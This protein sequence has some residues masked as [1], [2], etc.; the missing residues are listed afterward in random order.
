MDAQKARKLFEELVASERELFE[1]LHKDIGLFW[2]T[3]SQQLIKQIN[4]HGEKLSKD[5]DLKIPQPLIPQ[6]EH[7][8]KPILNDLQKR[9]EDSTKHI[10]SKL[11]ERELTEEQHRILQQAIKSNWPP[12]KI[13]EWLP[14]LK[15][16]SDQHLET[17]RDYF[18]ITLEREMSP[19]SIE[20]ILRWTRYISTFEKKTDEFITIIKTAV[21]EQWKDEDIQNLILHLEEINIGKCHQVLVEAIKQNWKPNQL[22]AFINQLKNMHTFNQDVLLCKLRMGNTLEEISPFIEISGVCA[23]FSKEHM[24]MIISKLYTTCTLPQL[25]EFIET[26]QHIPISQLEVLRSA[27]SQ[28]WTRDEIKEILQLLHTIQK[29]ENS[30]SSQALIE[31]CSYLI[32][33]LH[34]PS[35]VIGLITRL[36]ELGGIQLLGS[37]VQLQIITS[38]PTDEVLNEQIRL[39]RNKGEQ[40]VFWTAQGLHTRGYFVVHATNAYAGGSTGKIQ[41]KLDP[42]ENT[43]QDIRNKYIYQP[44]CSIIGKKMKQ[45]VVITERATMNGA[46]GIVLD[47]GYIYQSY[48]SDAGAIE[49]RSKDKAH[50]HRTGDTLLKPTQNE[51]I[52]SQKESKKKY[53]EVL[54][55]H[56]NVG[57]IFFTKGVR[58][59]HIQHLIELSKQESGKEHVNG[60][61]A[62]RTITF[63]IGKHIKKYFPV[64]EIDT[65]NNHMTIIFDPTPKGEETEFILDLRKNS[66]DTTSIKEFKEAA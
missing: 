53:N 60:Q 52:I 25:R 3:E 66:E 4:E 51:I 11:P 64:V 37:L 61:Y 43:L 6:Q 32:V 50:A 2:S 48:M 36:Q 62:Y 31:A 16:V 8:S 28:K 18:L 56:W 20:R 47:W 41:L 13:K 55:R 59:E 38:T 35:E 10:Q 58:Q 33:E 22:Y 57:E 14:S 65:S 12:E 7:I 15:N 24:A 1:L 19:N 17:I 40:K 44:S 34:T 29:K 54:V 49:K 21:N 46:I 27:L 39:F 26:I 23:E 45:S 30:L 5:L 42:W 63:G 9:M